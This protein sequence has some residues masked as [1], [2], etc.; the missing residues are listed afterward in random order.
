MVRLKPEEKPLY[1]A[2]RLEVEGKRL[3]DATKTG[4]AIV[5]SLNT[6]FFPLDYLLFPDHVFSMFL[7]R[8]A[9]NVGMAMIYW[10]LAKRYPLQSAVAGVMIVGVMLI[11]LI[12]EVGGLRGAYT[13]GLMLLFL[14]MPMLLPF[15]A[16]QAGGLIA[17]LLMWLGVMPELLGETVGLRGYLVGFGFP[18][19]AGMESVA[20]CAVLDRMRFAEFRQRREIERARDDLQELDA[21]KSRFTANV[22]HELR[23][24]L[25]LT[26]APVEAMLDGEFGEI[27]ELQQSY[28]QTVQTN[29]L[30]L[31]KLINNLLDLAKI[32]G[33]ELGISRRPIRVGG[34]IERILEDARP[35]GE[36]IGVEFSTRGL[37]QLP[38]ISADGEAVEK[39]FVNLVGNAL[40]FTKRGGQIVVKGRSASNGG[41]HVIVRDTGVGI[42]ADQLTRIFDRFAQVDG[43]NTREH[44]GT[45]IGLSLASELVAL[46]GGRIWA[47]SEGIG[48]GS[49]FHVMLPR[50]R[51]DS[52]ERDEAWRE[53]ILE[54]DDGSEV[55]LK[56]SLAAVAAEADSGGE[57]DADGRAAALRVVEL[58][59]TVE[60]AEGASASLESNAFMPDGAVNRGAEEVL[61]VEDNVDMRK[62]LSFL[63]GREF[64][65]RVARNGR[66]GLEMVRQRKP[67]LVLTDVM[68]PEMSGTELC[69]ALKG[70]PETQGIPVVLVT[71]KAERAMK[72]HGLELGADDYV[73]K[74]FHPRELIARIRSLL[75]LVRLQK[76]LAERNEAL[77]E[78]NDDLRVAMGEIKE[79]SAQLVHAE[80]LSALGELAAGIAH[81]I[82]N[83]VNFAVNAAKALQGCVKE[84]CEVAAKMAEV[85][86]SEP[87]EFARQSGEL[88]ALRKRIHFDERV[89]TLGE[90]AEIVNEGLERTARLVGDLRDFAVPDG[91]S[92][93]QLDITRGLRSTVQLI[94]HTLSKQKIT[95]RVEFPPDLPRIEGEARALNQVFLNLLK[96]AADSFAGRG[97][98]IELIARSEGNAVVVE[99]RDDGP[100]ISPEHRE[101]IFEPFFSTKEASAG[102]G[103][104]LSI[105]RRIIE[106]HGGSIEVEDGP[107]QGTTVRVRLPVRADSRRR[108]SDAS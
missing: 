26:L 4:A 5:A 21:A 40:K 100:G 98:S 13:P 12:G 45:G 47:E 20:A 44:G 84:V 81:E 103:L 25:T 32:E 94:G 64:R 88:D 43:S 27:T 11:G 91:P 67:D 75:R 36:R 42:A 28:L 102:T 57:E 73:T 35:M 8:M 3:S 82:N 39:I 23:T 87:A 50:G 66:E 14:G 72:I 58:E 9:C 80:R 90:L 19:A 78:A 77:E 96:N 1:R 65:L 97:G 108:A 74:P 18:L 10:V 48:H 56:Q 6:A 37:D 107:V 69:A 105:S 71:S 68:M 70:D 79:T 17:C 99:V 101:R 49:Q 76:E 92:N 41:I 95:I 61:V 62:L 63:I 38:E 93:A 51:T 89:D 2:Y 46:H 104:G 86:S 83:P 24:P 31:L 30:R 29:G 16:A 59:Q 7:G 34:A 33:N 53:A 106:E 52:A 60:R 55:T 22:H 54:A 15:S 85:E